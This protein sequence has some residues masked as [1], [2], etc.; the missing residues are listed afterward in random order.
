MLIDQNMIFH[1]ENKIKQKIAKQPT[2]T[3]FGP[4]KMVDVNYHT[5]KC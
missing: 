4:L 1:L 3:I 2:F 5:N